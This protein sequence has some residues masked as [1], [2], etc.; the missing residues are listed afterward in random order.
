MVT[1]QWEEAVS[2]WSECTPG[3][4]APWNTMM[5]VRYPRTLEGKSALGFATLPWACERSQAL[6]GGPG[7]ASEHHNSQHLS[8]G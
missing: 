3:E 6:K 1:G 5:L 7:T 2:F 8:S 4:L